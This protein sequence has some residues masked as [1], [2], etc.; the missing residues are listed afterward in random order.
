[1]F[2][3]ALMNCWQFGQCRVRA[4]QVVQARTWPQGR[5]I[6]P[7]LF[8]WHI[9]Q[10]CLDRR[11]S[12]SVLSCCAR[13]E[14]MAEATAAAAAAP[15]LSVS[16]FSWATSGPVERQEEQSAHKLTRFWQHCYYN[17][18]SHASWHW[19]WRLKTKIASCAFFPLNR[20][21]VWNNPF[22]KTFNI[23][24]RLYSQ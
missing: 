3:V 4:P 15:M 20:G 7:T 23:I 11:R 22:P 9:L 13:P 21:R 6:M 19:P 5:K 10:I 8:L 12:F 2:A 14:S 1:M 17:W 24:K 18:T 16:S